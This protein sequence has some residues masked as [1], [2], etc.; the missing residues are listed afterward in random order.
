MD[1]NVVLQSVPIRADTNP[2]II[3][4]GDKCL[5]CQ[6]HPC[7]RFCPS[8]CFSKNDQGRIDYYYVGCVECGTC[9]L[10]CS[11]GAVAWEYPKGG[12]GVA[13]RY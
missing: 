3:V 12:F 5:H 2:H 8:Q 4:D 11:K 1:A 7:I 9:F 10:A 6:T 13:Y